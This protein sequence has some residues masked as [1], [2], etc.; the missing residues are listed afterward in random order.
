[1]VSQAATSTRMTTT[2][3]TCVQTARTS[4]LLHRASAIPTTW[5]STSE[6]DRLA[7]LHV[8]PRRSQYLAGHWLLREM[9]A[10]HCGGTPTDWP[11][12]ERRSL[13]PVVASSDNPAYLSIAH[14][15]EWI[16]AAIATTPIGIDIEQRH[17]QRSLTRFE[18]L[19]LAT[20]DSPGTLGEDE[21]LQRWVLK[22]AHIKRLCG[23]ALPEQLAAVRLTRSG[24]IAANV[25]L[26][27]SA[28]FHLGVA[29]AAGARLQ[30]LGIDQTRAAEYWNTTP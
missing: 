16:A 10:Q 25:R 28:G 21:L 17:P 8:E 6:Q 9:L 24:S 30:L 14:S 12:Q 7:R 27:T 22:E 19:L 23:S 1:M 26:Y 3:I 13:P 20:H 11:L 4:D 18:H 15:G 5:L 29:A 2:D